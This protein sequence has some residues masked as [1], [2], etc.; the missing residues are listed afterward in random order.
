[1]MRRLDWLA[2]RL[3]ENGAGLLVIPKWLVTCVRAVPPV[4]AV[5]FWQVG[6]RSDG[7]ETG[8]WRHAVT[9]NQVGWFIMLRNCPRPA[10]PRWLSRGGPLDIRSTGW[11]GV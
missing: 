7:G 5:D 2:H 8:R 11:S 4:R 6:R 1:M 10:G 3:V 9:T